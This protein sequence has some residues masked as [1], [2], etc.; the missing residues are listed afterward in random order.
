VRQQNER[1][2]ALVMVLIVIA[3]LALIA[4]AF[5]WSIRSHV[6]LTANI[7]ASAEAEALADGG[8]ELA[9]LDL[10]AVRE[11]RLRQRRFPIDGAP[12]SCLA[13]GGGVLAIMAGD[14]AGKVDLNAAGEPLLAALI[15]GTGT[16]RTIAERIAAAIA[17]FRDADDTTRDGG[18]ERKEY[19]ASGRASG[20]KNAPFAVTEEL[21]QV[22]GVTPE[23]A[24]AL[25][26]HVTVHSGLTGV[27]PSAMTRDLGQL[28]A[29]GSGQSGGLSGSLPPAFIAST[30][31]RAFSIKVDAVAPNGARFVRDALVELVGT[32]DNHVLRRWSRDRDVG[33]LRPLP[34]GLPPC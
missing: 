28:L 11:D 32:R 8:V 18:A 31:R 26:P 20:P 23:L 15:S 34:G 3:L 24:A 9:I 1:G 13:P 30:T 19:V 4:S 27:D 17:D 6:R 10:L 22:L 2:F 5:S 25:R 14:E 21:G 16:N 33:A 7:A 12:V 29:A